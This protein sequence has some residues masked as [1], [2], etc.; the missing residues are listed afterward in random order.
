[1]SL[2]DLFHQRI[3][4]YLVPRDS[5]SRRMV[6]MVNDNERTACYTITLVALNSI[7]FGMH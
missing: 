1:M 7:V 5:A 2:N 6:F 3:P 4:I